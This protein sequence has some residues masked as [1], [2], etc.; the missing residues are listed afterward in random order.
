[1]IDFDPNNSAPEGSGMFALPYDVEDASLVV[2]PVPWDATSSQARSSA[3]APDSVLAASKYVELF[4]PK[5]GALYQKGIAMDETREEISGLNSYA[6]AMQDNAAFHGAL[7][8]EPCERLN[9]IVERQVAGHLAAGK[10]V[11]LLGGD[12]SVVTDR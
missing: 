11:G 1:M 3:A 2:V 7:L 8:T 4:D 9:N 10:R 12:H 6:I 5:L